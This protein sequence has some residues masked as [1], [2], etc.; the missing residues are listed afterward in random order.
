MTINRQVSLLTRNLRYFETPL[1]V[2]L[3]ETDGFADQIVT[4]TP[5]GRWGK[6]RDL[7]GAVIFLASPAS[8]YVSGL[9]VVVD[10]GMLGR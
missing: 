6:P 9:S 3:R 8:D 7:C 1:T 10:G 2:S 5:A 4:R